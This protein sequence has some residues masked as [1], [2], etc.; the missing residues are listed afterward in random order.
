MTHGPDEGAAAGTA[1]GAV[2]PASRISPVPWDARPYQGQRAGV[3]T[4]LTAGILDGFVVGLVLAAGYFGLSFVLFLVNPR[5]FSL[6]RPG[7]VFS[8]TSAFVVAF[9]YFTVAWAIGGRT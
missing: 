9:V 8:L 7:L 2:T 3:V 5:G 4:R 1:D 6:P